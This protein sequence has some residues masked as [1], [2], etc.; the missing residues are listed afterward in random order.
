ML[1]IYIP[2]S[3]KGLVTKTTD[4][5]KSMIGQHLML[6]LVFVISF[7]LFFVIYYYVYRVLFLNKLD[8]RLNKILKSF[9]V[10]PG[11]VLVTNSYVKNYFDQRK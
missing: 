11:E 5:V 4:E 2:E 6:G 3:L 7:P 10:L 8:D 9:L 1:V